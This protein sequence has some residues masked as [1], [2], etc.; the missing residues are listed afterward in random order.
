MSLPCSKP[1]NGPRSHTEYMPE[2]LLGPKGLPCGLW[3]LTSL[4][5]SSLLSSSPATVASRPFFRPARLAPT[6]G[7][8][9][10]F[11]LC[12]DYSSSRYLHGS[13]ASPFF[14]S[15]L[16][17]HLPEE[18]FSPPQTLLPPLALSI[19]LPCFIF[20]FFYCIYHLLT[21]YAIYLKKHCLLFVPFT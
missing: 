9:A 7:P 6:W 5:C 15:L 18:T 2:T 16:S 12:L 8:C 19:P 1:F 13:P 20:F 4:I 10:S 11:S 21:D 14:K 17:C 3:L